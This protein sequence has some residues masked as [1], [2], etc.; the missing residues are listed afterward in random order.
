MGT[1]REEEDAGILRFCRG[2][3]LCAGTTVGIFVGFFA[4]WNTIV[5]GQA[6]WKPAWEGPPHQTFLEIRSSEMPWAGRMLQSIFF[7]EK[8]LESWLYFSTQL[9]SVFSVVEAKA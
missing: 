5:Q 1:V 7:K 3:R 9:L 6:F 2:A 4:S 8:G